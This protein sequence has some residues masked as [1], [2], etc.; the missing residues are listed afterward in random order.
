MRPGAGHRGNRK[1]RYPLRGTGRAKAPPA[2]PLFPAVV[3]ILF[4]V[5]RLSRFIIVFLTV[6]SPVLL[7]VIPVDIL[8]L[9]ITR[10]TGRAMAPFGS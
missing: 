8:V 1:N 3:H 2:R 10:K 9:T 7:I 5:L 6:L 4:P